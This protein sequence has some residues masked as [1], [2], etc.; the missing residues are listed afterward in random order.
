MKQVLGLLALCGLLAVPAH[1]QLQVSLTDAV[2]SAGDPVGTGSNASPAVYNV[3]TST[4]FRW[5]G[6]IWQG[7]SGASVVANIARLQATG[8]DPTGGPCPVFAGAINTGSNQT[9]GCVDGIWKAVA[10]SAGGGGS[11][12]VSVLGAGSLTSTACVTGAGTTVIQT[13]SSLCT[14]DSSGN[15]AVNS[16]AVGSSAPAI[17]WFTG[18]A[19]IWGETSGTC[20]GTVPAGAGFFTTCSGVPTWMTNSASSAFCLANGSGCPTI[21]TVTGGT[22]TN[23]VVTAISS[24]VV[25]TCTTVTSAYVDSSIAKTGASNTFSAGTQD[26][27]GAAHTLTMK[28]VAN[29]GA[30]PGTCTQGELTFVSAATAGQQ[31]YECS[32]TNT[33]TQQSGGGGGSGQQPYVSMPAV[34][35]STFPNQAGY[36]STSTF[37]QSAGDSGNRV[38]VRFSN[39]NN[40]GNL[41]ALVTSISSVSNWTHTVQ[42][43]PGEVLT[44]QNF[45]EYG[46]V[47]NDGTQYY[48]CGTTYFAGDKY[49]EFS[50]VRWSTFSTGRTLVAQAGV[51][52]STPAYPVYFRMNW[53]AASHSMQCQYSFDG[54]TF[55]TVGTDTTITN[56]TNI[57]VGINPV[58]FPAPAGYSVT[59]YN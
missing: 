43:I 48:M 17:S 9:F 40:T 54:D 42:V 32:A 34:T 4:L 33:W 2:F 59:G 51:Y 21:P 58:G 35:T 45:L 23:Q 37:T 30:L 49:W 29:V 11:G 46:L 18:T 55:L 57:G 12:T 47:I 19:G 28:V 56:P 52:G 26:M 36:A 15:M 24:S 50:F 31:I 8:T 3:T 20:G 41:S 1:A 25:P 13:P 14:V 27:S 44:A 39:A 53:T 10:V 7:V 6:A 16:I 5:N 38:Y 22:C